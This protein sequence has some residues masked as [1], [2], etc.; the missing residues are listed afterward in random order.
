[1]GNSIFLTAA[2]ARQNPFQSRTVF[3]EGTA[4]SSVILDR[5]KT[6]YYS[7]IINGG[8]PMTQQT[9]TVTGV[10]SI[11]SQTSTLTMP[12]HGLNTG[13]AVYVY[14]TGELPSP[15]QVNVLYFVIYV[16]PN[17]IQLAATRQDAFAARPIYIV[18]VN[19]L[20]AID[21]TNQ[22]TGYTNVPVVTISGG[23]AT[24][25]ATAMAQLGQYGNISYIVVGSQGGGY[26]YVPSV[27]IV[28][29]GS[30]A[31]AGTITFVAVNGTVNAGGQYYHLGD[32][33]TVVGG[34]GTSAT[35]TVT[36]VGTNGAVLTVALS[37]I[38]NY[39]ALPTL[40]GVATTVSPGGGT[41]CTLN[42]IMGIGSIA[43][44]TGGSQYTA[45]PVINITGGGG[46]N[47][48]SNAILTAGSLSSIQMTNTGTGYTSAPT[49]TFVSGDG[50]TATPY[51][52]PTG[53]GN[54]NLLYNG[55]NTYT[56][57]PG[58]TIT[59]QGSGATVG[60]VSMQMIAATIVTGGGGNGYAVGDTLIV[61]GGQ[62]S[63][64]ATIGVNTV[65]NNGSI[66]SW[67]LLTSGLYTEL[68][69]MNYN[70]VYGGSGTAASFNLVAGL[71]NVQITSGGS[72]YTAPP[73]LIITPNDLTG[74]GAS[75]YCNMSNGSVTTVTVTA[76]GSGYTAVPTISITNGSGATAVSTL[77]PTSVHLV[78]VLTGGSGYTS[79]N[80][81]LVSDVGMGALAIATI[82]GGQIVA[83]SVTN[84]GYGYTN[85][86]TVLI[87]GDGNGATA[88][89][90]LNATSV[91]SL[92]ITNYGENY[93]SI[94][95]VTVAGAAT[96]NVTLYST[97]IQQIVVTNGGEYYT[98][99]PQ[100]NVIPGAGETVQPTQPSTS[101]IRGF[102]VESIQ[103]VD[104][105]QGYDSA[106]TVTISA[107]H[108]LNGNTATAT[109]SIGYGMGNMT[110]R[111]YPASRDYYLVWQNGQA[112]NPDLTGPYQ[113]NMA[114]VMAYFTN[115][116]YTI[117]QQTNPATNN[118]FQWNVKW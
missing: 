7:A 86:P 52:V 3:D 55:G 85:P 26:H 56:L 96:A 10:V 70:A 69:V 62:G 97:G 39:S 15:L 101:V 72:G 93:T 30:G 35:F 79:A 21:I 40:S 28:A 102:S 94:P 64:T 20:T 42:L 78:N 118:T 29:Q 107:P 12:N 45:P 87:S 16:N 37:G 81:E 90:V 53:V 23:N 27:S 17:E 91:A 73:T 34:T 6:G 32:T 2:Q 41:G 89:A 14:S 76:P 80:V 49:V 71:G 11:D 58:V 84:P 68:P 24:V 116:G 67:T 83:I 48:T 74:Y 18:L 105:G 75:G 5:V 92:S 36:N 43:V 22:G 109:A 117:V 25:G 104:Q 111:S 47:A 108:N 44:A 82:S 33:L 51:L 54:I 112:V 57:P 114:T 88:Q 59:P 115:L 113:D 65:D 4:I 61:A 103:I 31:S 66:I 8:T 13:D 46:I 110:V 1:M 19:G 9:G 77:A 98:S 100:V 95:A 50:A 106:P 60:T 38:G 63:A 99:N